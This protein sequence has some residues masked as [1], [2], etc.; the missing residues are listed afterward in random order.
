MFERRFDGGRVIDAGGDGDAHVLAGFDGVRVEAGADDE[1]RTC[2][3]GGFGLG[4]VEDGAGGNQDVRIGIA[5]AADGFSGSG[6][7]EGDFGDGDAAFPQGGAKRDGIGGVIQGDD[8]DDFG[9]AQ[10][11]A[12]GGDVHVGSFRVGYLGGGLK[13]ALRL[14]SG[15]CV[16]PR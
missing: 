5:Q 15:G 4:S 2:L 9:G 8:G 14:S 7:A 11:F 6:G 1:V 13:P 3:L 12:Q 16:L 10:A